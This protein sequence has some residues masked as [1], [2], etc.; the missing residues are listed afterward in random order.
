MLH[1]QEV[2]FQFSLI[3]SQKRNQQINPAFCPYR[4]FL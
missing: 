4:A 3:A 2:V 1:F